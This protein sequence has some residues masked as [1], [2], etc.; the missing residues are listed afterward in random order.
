LEAFDFA[1]GSG[2]VGSGVFLLDA[3]FSQEGFETVAAGSGT[4]ESGG[5]VHAVVGKHRGWE[6]VLACGFFEPGDH[7]WCGDP[8]VCGD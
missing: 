3:V 6:T 1:A 2:V 4:C 7:D 5:V 8:L